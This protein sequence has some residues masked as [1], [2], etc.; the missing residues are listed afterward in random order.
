MKYVR[1]T[2]PRGGGWGGGHKR[3]TLATLAAL[4]RPFVQGICQKRIIRAIGDSES[5]RAEGASRNIKHTKSG[6]GKELG[7][8][9]QSLK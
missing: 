8:K 4:S 6:G 5:I 2:R 3:R 1:K 7:K 9:H